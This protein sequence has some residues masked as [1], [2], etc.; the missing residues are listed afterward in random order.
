M[1][2]TSMK[3]FRED[4]DVVTAATNNEGAVAEAITRFVLNHT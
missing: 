1:S 4:C 3:Q 2:P